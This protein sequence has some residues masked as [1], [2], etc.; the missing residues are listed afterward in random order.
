MKTAFRLRRNQ[1][2]G[3]S[4]AS[5]FWKATTRMI[6]LPLIPGQD[7]KVRLASRIQRWLQLVHQLLNPAIRNG[8]FAVMRVVA[9]IWGDEQKIW[10]R[11]RR[12]VRGKLRERNNAAIT[13]RRIQT[14][15]LKIYE[16]IMFHGVTVVVR[17]RKA[18]RRHV[19][20]I[21]FPRPPAGLD[22]IW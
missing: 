9:K 8:Y 20:L 13:A 21:R 2:G 6:S 17:S 22:L 18:R 14:D 5:Q 10:E 7:D 12:N 4:S 1:D 15:R 19:L 16:R 11:A 3:D